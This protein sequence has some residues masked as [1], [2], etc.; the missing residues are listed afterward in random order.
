[1]TPAAFEILLIAIAISVGS[2]LLNK[3]LVN[4]DRADEIKRKIKDFQ[5]RFNE[6]KKSGDQA[7][8]KKLEEEQREVLGLTKELMSN[9]FKPLL[10]TFLPFMI[11][12]FFLSNAY[13]SAGIVVTIPIFNWSLTWLWWYILI[14]VFAGLIFEAFYKF[15]RKSKAKPKIEQTVEQ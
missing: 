5:N 6:A 7:L 1:M 4:Q 14:S 15:Y 8:I 11:I 13:G 3:K 12:L 2:A 10:Y 9:S